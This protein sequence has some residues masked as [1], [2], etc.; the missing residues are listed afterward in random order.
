MTAETVAECL[1][2]PLYQVCAGELSTSAVELEYTLTR[3]FRLAERWRAILLIDEADVYMEQ[4]APQDLVRNG[5]VS[6]FLRNLEYCRSV[7]FMT[8]NRV[9]TFDEAITSRMHV[10]IAYRDNDR[11]S[12]EQIW[13]AFLDTAVTVEGSA[14]IDPRDLDDLVG[15][16][17]NARQVSCHKR[18]GSPTL[19]PR[20][21]GTP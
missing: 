12:R 4:R 9:K 17:L 14:I 20:R 18:F 13:K 6:V 21:S 3:L 8:T 19:M 10:M 2:V 15:R 5:L 1:R 16:K 11:D 7:V